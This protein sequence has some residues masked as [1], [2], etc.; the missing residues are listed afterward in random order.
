MPR[1]DEHLLPEDSPY[2]II[3]GVRILTMANPEHAGPQLDLGAV[4]RFSVAEGYRAM[5][6]LTTRADTLPPPAD[7]DPLAEVLPASV[8]ELRSDAS[9]L[10]LGTDPRTGDRYV[11]DM[12]FELANEQSLAALKV[13]AR[14][15]SERGVRRVFGVLVKKRRLLEWSAGQGDFVLLREDDHLE[16]RCLRQPIRVKALLDAAEADTAI[17]QALVARNHPVIAEVREAG[18]KIGLEQGLR[19]TVLD[20]CEVLGLTVSPLQRAAIERLGV[21]DLERLRQGLKSTRSWP[22][23]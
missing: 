3:D 1:L 2:E 6:E 10:R 22:M 9:I 7:M 19:Q 18:H 8:N 5:V 23:A 4:L 11:E 20:L 17:A 15:L 14:K 16:D 21:A 12:S 13:K